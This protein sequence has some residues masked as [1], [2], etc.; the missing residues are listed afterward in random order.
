[1]FKIGDKVIYQN[2]DKNGTIEK[3]KYVGSVGTILSVVPDPTE[4]Y[5]YEIEFRDN[6]TNFA[7][8]FFLFSDNEL[9]FADD[10]YDCF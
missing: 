9:Y 6:E 8:C 7:L 1:M 10:Y 3:H 2:I 5:K 4:Y